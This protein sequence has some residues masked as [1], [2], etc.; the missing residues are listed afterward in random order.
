[1][2]DE[3]FYVQGQQNG[4]LRYEKSKADLTS[5]KKEKEK[6]NT[7]HKTSTHHTLGYTKIQQKLDQCH[8]DHVYSSTCDETYFDLFDFYFQNF[9]QP[10]V[11]VLKESL[12]CAQEITNI[13]WL[14]MSLSSRGLN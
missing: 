3:H 2:S 10:E 12:S 8:N 14:F 9:K 1:M 13:R 5:L 6:E 7:Q 11:P 4:S